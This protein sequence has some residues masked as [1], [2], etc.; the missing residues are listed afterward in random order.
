MT[1][2]VMVDLRTEAAAEVVRLTAARALTRDDDE[3][4]RIRCE[5]DG[6]WITGSRGPARRA[7]LG[8]RALMI[9]RLT[10]EDGNGRIVESRLAGVVVR[11]STTCRLRGR[12]SVD[13]FLRN[14]E[15]DVRER[16]DACSR[17]WREASAHR[18]RAFAGTRVSRERA[19]AASPAPAER[20]Q[21]GLFDHRAHRDRAVQL[22]AAA[23]TA[24]CAA[25]RLSGPERT[26]TL[27]QRPAQLLLVLLP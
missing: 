22:A 19:V 13:A 3:P 17:H 5:G 15:P 21:A 27:V 26:A 23:D 25:D 24:R 10:I 20:F 8:R 11:L 12:A 9:W 6:P 4:A 7:R 16:L 1:T 2:M 14:V 18:V